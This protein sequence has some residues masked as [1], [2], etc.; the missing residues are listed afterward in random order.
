MT[1]RRTNPL[2]DANLWTGNQ[3]SGDCTW[4][5][6]LN[7]G[8][9]IELGAAL[10][11]VKEV[12]LEH[13]TQDMFPLPGLSGRL[14]SLSQDLRFGRGF[15]LVR[16]FPVDN[17]KYEDIERMYW[18]LCTHLGVGLTQNGDGSFIHYVTDGKLRP[19]QGRRGVGFPKESKLHIDLTDIVSLLCVQQAP[20][21]PASRVASSIY[22]HNEFQKRNMAGLPSLYEG[23]EWDRMDEHAPYETPT[24][25]YK[26]P[27]FSEKDG[28]ISCQYNRN[29][30]NNA[31]KR[32]GELLT[33]RVNANFD[34]LDQI[35]F[36]GCF[37][38]AF[39]KGD[40]Q[41]CNNY[42]VMHGRAAHA[43]V[44]EEPLKR[45]LMR[46]WLD[47]PGQ[48]RPFVDDPLI[49]YGN[50]RHGQIGWSASE[51]LAGKNKEPRTRR[52]DGAIKI[53]G[54]GL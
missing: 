47:M 18:G 25:G 1:N 36:E 22:V 19:N 42:T 53:E 23:F 6:P 40:V 31:A 28:Y 4:E 45:V 5:Y 27:L 32:K 30:I 7:E 49:R 8:D 20:D 14:A 39:K 37:E 43:Y 15:A 50:G 2:K 48:I 44:E 21:A 13:I 16:G 46:V 11:K 9:R 38:F 54:Y 24:S 35:A 3:L 10:E 34:L 51:V 52:A 12:N 33:P 29:W 17:F 26:I 41:F